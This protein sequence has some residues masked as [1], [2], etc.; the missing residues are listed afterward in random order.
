MTSSVKIGTFV[1]QCGAEFVNLDK[2]VDLFLSSPE[3]QQTSSL[4]VPACVGSLD[5]AESLR[6]MT[7]GS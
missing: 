4:R 7:P 3:S 2:R 1:L 6:E 5:K